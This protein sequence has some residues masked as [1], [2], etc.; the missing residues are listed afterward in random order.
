MANLSET[1][2]F[3]AG[4]Y[5]LELT[6]PVIGGPSGISNTPLKNLANRTKYL[7]DHV[8]ALET[9]RAPL[10][11][12]V[13][14][15]NPTAPTPASTDND[16][17]IATTA[18]VKTAIQSLVSGMRNRFINGDFRVDQRNKGSAVSV[19]IS[20]SAVYPVDRWF[21]QNLGGGGAFTA[22]RSTDAPA[23]FT[24]SLSITTSSTASISAGDSRIL[25]HY[26]EGNLLYDTDFGLATASAIT[27]TFRV[28]SSLAGTFSACFSN[29]D[30]T[31]IYG[32]TFV[33]N[34]ANTW[35]TKS[36]VIPGDVS[37]TWAKDENWGARLQINLGSG[38]DMLQS[39]AGAWQST[40]NGRGVVGGVSLIST[41]S[42]YLRIAGCQ[43]EAGNSST[44]FERRAFGYELFLCQRYYEEVW[45][46]WATAWGAGMNNF[47]SKFKVSKRTVPTMVCYADSNPFTKTGAIGNVWNATN[48]AN[49]PIGAAFADTNQTDGFVIDYNSINSNAKNMRATVTASAE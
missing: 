24:N 9:S 4:V 18:F 26:F 37:G 5:Q 12:P 13:L 29:A 17:S 34:A 47:N 40:G 27:L 15:G 36:I 19:P 32:F 11:S 48:S 2:T 21:V 28:K 23:G 35:E 22:Q 45:C 14:T 10:D 41:A 8:D 1:S 49:M 33:I 6:D 44:P 43:L 16:T 20:S 31:R 38:N 3:D 30:L 25:A 46:Q 7:K 39:S 42:A